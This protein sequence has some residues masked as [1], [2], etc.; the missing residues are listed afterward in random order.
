MFLSVLI[1]SISF[2]LLLPRLVLPGCLGGWLAGWMAGFG[3]D[4]ESYLEELIVGRLGLQLAA[5]FDGLFEF[6]GLG[7]SHIDDEVLWGCCASC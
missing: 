3:K 6:C 5:V 7:D 2:F 4:G 1:H